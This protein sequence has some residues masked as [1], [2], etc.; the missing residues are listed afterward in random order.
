MSS[1]QNVDR[2]LIGALES[3]PSF[4]LTL[5]DL[6]AI[7][8]GLLATL[9]SPTQM[10]DGVQQTQ[11][12]VPGPNGAP[13]VR[14]F[15]YRPTPQRSGLPVLLHLHGGGHIMGSPLISETLNRSFA[16]K[17][18]CV[19]VSVQYRLSP[20]NPFPASLEDAYAALRWIFVNA[21]ELQ[22][23][24]SRIAV[25][26][27]SAGGGLAASIAQMALDNREIPL[28]F[29]L[30]TYPMLDNRSGIFCDRG[31]HAGRFVWTAESNRFAWEAFLSGSSINEDRPYAVP[32][33][34]VNLAGLPPTFIGV[35]AIDLFAQEDIEYAARLLQ[36]DVPTELHVYPG[37]YH[38]FDLASGWGAESLIE[39]RLSALRRAFQM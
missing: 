25:G 2:D 20:E 12:Y 8:A 33:R 9:A 37:A 7:R 1:M 18:G 23:D 5:E 36:S 24:P 38:G 39:H 27:E 35:G 22:I 14:V 15:I 34:R 32:A 10:D 13:D 26:G 29:Q 3:M 19:V 30:L 17:I 16:A 11:R 31:L 4:K 28:I 21:G 6:P